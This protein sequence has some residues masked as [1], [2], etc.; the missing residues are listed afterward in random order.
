[1]PGSTEL[2]IDRH[3]RCST[4]LGRRS[5][6]TRSH[7]SHLERGRLQVFNGIVLPCW[8]CDMLRWE[9]LWSIQMLW[10]CALL[11]W[12][13]MHNLIRLPDKFGAMVELHVG[14][15]RVFSRL[16]TDC[17]SVLRWSLNS[18]LL[19]LSLLQVV[20]SLYRSFG[21]AKVCRF[22]FPNGCKSALK[23]IANIALTI[24]IVYFNLSKRLCTSRIK[25][26]VQWLFR[27]SRNFRSVSLFDF[28]HS[29]LILLFGR[30]VVVCRGRCRDQRAVRPL[31][32][33]AV[34]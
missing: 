29:A 32:H 17:R 20:I 30:R 6:V 21:F 11:V 13:M 24:A 5:I 26:V 19:Q 12:D 34:I 9:E 15:Y 2:P 23:G 14:S 27:L 18:L 16:P 7:R 28:N 31:E 1:M 4:I 25:Y 33:L 3:F 22:R 8:Y 10:R